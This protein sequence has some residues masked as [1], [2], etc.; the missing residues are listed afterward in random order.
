MDEIV[1]AIID[2]GIPVLMLVAVLFFIKHYLSKSIDESFSQNQ[3]EYQKKIDLFLLDY[4]KTIDKNLKENE[5]QFVETIQ[6]RVE[7][8]LEI[9]SF[10]RDVTTP[11][12]MNLG[13]LVEKQHLVDEVMCWYPDET[14]TIFRNLYGK[15]IKGLNSID[16]ITTIEWHADVEPLLF[17]VVKSI[18]PESNL[19]TSP[20][21][22]LSDIHTGY[23][24]LPTMRIM[25]PE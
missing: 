11:D 8:A 13:Q 9:I 14:Y 7:I 24:F 20:V 22:D 3:L 12:C 15:C 10:C 16:K 18:R 4:K 21:I 6:Q 23:H 1:K 19:I 17:S 25:P 5:L 2:G